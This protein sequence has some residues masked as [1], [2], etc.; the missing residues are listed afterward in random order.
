MTPQTGVLSCLPSSRLLYI[1]L[2]YS[3]YKQF[4]TK[5][6]GGFHSP[7]GAS[8]FVRKDPPFPQQRAPVKTN[9]R[10]TVESRICI[11]HSLD[12]DSGLGCPRSNNSL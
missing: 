9:P 7:R 12:V 10:S 4:E 1:H 3:C 11:E 8:F 5:Y 6:V 2:L